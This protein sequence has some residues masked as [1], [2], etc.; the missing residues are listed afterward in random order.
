M[1]DGVICRRPAGK[2]EEGMLSGNGTMGIMVMG[3]PVEERVIVCHEKL[4]EPLT[5][6]LVENKDISEHLPEIRRLLLAGR[7]RDAAAFMSE[8]SGHTLVSSESFHPAFAFALQRDAAGE[9]KEYSRAT[10]FETGEVSVSWKDDAGSHRRRAF[11]SRTDG[12][13][14]WSI[15]GDEVKSSVRIVEQG[16]PRA[17]KS[18]SIENDGEWMT[19]RCKYFYSKRGYVGI[20]RVCPGEGRYGTDGK[21]TRTRKGLVLTKVA[22][23]EDFAEAAEAVSH[24][25]AELAAIEPDYD[26]LLARHAEVHGEMFRR[27]TLNLCAGDDA[28]SEDLL[29]RQKTGQIEAGLLQ[30]MFEMGR[31][32]LI[33]ASGKWPPNLVGLWT[34][35][36]RC[37]WGGSY[38]LDANLNLAISGGNI[39]NL[40]ECMESYFRLI[41]GLLPDWRENARLLY[42][43]R[44]ILSPIAT[45]GRRGIHNHFNT[46]WP[47]AMW[48]GGAEWL[49]EPFWEYCQVFGDDKFLRERLLPLMKEAALFYEDFLK[50]QD[51]GS[52]S[53]Q[54][55]KFVFAPAYSPENTPSGQ[56]AGQ[57]SQAGVNS[58]MDIAAARELF[59]NLISACERFGIE[60]GNLPKWKAMLA[61][62]PEYMVNED[63]ALREWTHKGLGENYDHR[64]E[65]HLYPAW[66]GFEIGPDT[67]ELFA[68]ARKALE[69]RKPQNYSAHGFMH[70]ALIAA[71]LRMPEMIGACL[72]EILAHDFIYD[73]LATSHYPNGRVYNM[74]ACLSLPTVVMEM[75]VFS[76]PGVIDLLPAVPKGLEKG[77]IDGI[78][79]RCGVKVEGL[80]WDLEAGGVEVV[81][82]SGREQEITLSIPWR[83]EQFDMTSGFRMSG[84]HDNCGTATLPAGKN[85]RIRLGFKLP[86][87]K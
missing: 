76:K 83:I 63:G 2:W 29:S 58:T 46:D 65:S 73:S 21:I 56:Q 71:R 48:T 24:L 77:S 67:P 79:C 50:L 57:V 7:Y 59:V 22:V 68:A 80:A 40:P 54:K 32:A 51:D 9:V 52:V 72:S 4:Y 8:K 74:D 87:T 12:V 45:S 84:K 53:G 60:G 35:K 75:L 10:N 23:L 62:M 34:G 47:L 82:R 20:A 69:L 1:R 27:V 36:W 49:L 30:K 15:E 44:G 17:V 18:I 64:H 6:G 25:K 66:P 16:L 43:C 14:A 42:G 28:T 3:G 86:G 81:L 41:E 78:M 85:V 26:R 55:G 19:F 13:F 39:G 31:Y 37:E 70:K 33:S 11:V 61:K 5:P 38:T